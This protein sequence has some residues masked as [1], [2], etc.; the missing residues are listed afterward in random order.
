MPGTK[1][2]RQPYRPRHAGHILL[3]EQRDQLAAPVHFA[4]LGLEMGN[5][6]KQSRHTLAAF[7]NVAT[8]LAHKI[9]DQAECH[10]LETGQ[11]AILSLDERHARTRR[12][13][14][15][16]AQIKALR[17]AITLGDQLL[18]RANSATLTSCLEWVY[19]QNAKTEH[20]LGS[21]DHPIEEAA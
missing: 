19:T 2:P 3:P 10:I 21:T 8:A 4:L 17:Q 11:R 1:R 18:K 13:S 15:D 20:T 14:L 9:A 12:W 5:G 16:A 7:L 6:G